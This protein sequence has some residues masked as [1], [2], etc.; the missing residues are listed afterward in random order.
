MPG[1]IRTVKHLFRYTLCLVL[2]LL[3]LCACST[4]A[5]VTEDSFWHMDTV[6]SIRLYGNGEI[7]KDALAECGGLLAS[8]DSQLSATRQ[9]SLIAQFNASEDGTDVVFP[10]SIIT[11]LD[12]AL[13]IGAV[14]NGA[15]DITTAPLT[16][17][18]QQYENN[19]LLP[20]EAALASVLSLV[21][22]EHLVIHNDRLCKS[23]ASVQ[24]D[25]GGIGKGY[26]LDCLL[27]YLTEKAEL[28]GGVISF[29][30]TVGVFGTKPDGTPFTIA[31]RD[32]NDTGAI[33]ATVH[34]TSG[35]VLS[36]S[37]DYERYFTIN[38]QK[39]SHILDPTTGFPPSNGLRSVA[40]VVTDGVTADALSTALMVMGEDASHALYDTGELDFEAIF[41]YD[42]RVTTTPGITLY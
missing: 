24:I 34:L 41:L 2:S 14:C 23:N 8:L 35:S 37:G 4:Q 5:S 29:G 6:I 38:G 27:D 30:S 7:A 1:N 36:V 42:D 16:R 18:W 32:P 25:L 15:F 20:E 12:Q 3:L 22:S 31:I 9:D 11:L 10:P 33:A 13:T 26:A 17:L 28:T 39:Y 19:N 40:V 21:G